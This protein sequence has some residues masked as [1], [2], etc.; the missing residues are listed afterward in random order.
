MYLHIKNYLTYIFVHEEMLHFV[1]LMFWFGMSEYF[2][3]SW[4]TIKNIDETW[5]QIIIVMHKKFKYYVQK[6]ECHPALSL[7]SIPIWLQTKRWRFLLSHYFERHYPFNIHCTLKTSFVN[8][9]TKLRQSLNLTFLLC[10]VRWNPKNP[11]NELTENR[12]P[13]WQQW[14]KNVIKYK[15]QHG[16]KDHMP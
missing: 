5:R 8:I 6:L 3:S 1:V 2:M 11:Q 15:F 4:S 12:L 16:N 13:N 14:N 7:G 10:L 9:E